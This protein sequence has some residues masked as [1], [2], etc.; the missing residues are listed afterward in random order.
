MINDGK[1][2]IHLHHKKIDNFCMSISLRTKK[3]GESN[4]RSL[5]LIVMFLIL[6][7]LLAA[8]KEKS[9]DPNLNL[10]IIETNPVAQIYSGKPNVGVTVVSAGAS[11][12]TD[13]AICWGEAPH[14]D[15]NGDHRNFRLQIL[16]TLI[17]PACHFTTSIREQSTT[18]AAMQKTPTEKY[19]VRM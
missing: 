14:P 15:L 16:Q 9:T 11:P 6:I 2:L 19:G 8:C 3:S 10:P 12:I 17:L 7:L 13:L 5:V 1:P 18:C 4:M